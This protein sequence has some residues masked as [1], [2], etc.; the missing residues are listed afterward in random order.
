MERASGDT[1]RTKDSVEEMEGSEVPN[2]ITDPNA[3][4]TKPGEGIDADDDWPHE[5]REEGPPTSQ[6]PR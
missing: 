1:E 4:L 2:P 3:R 5:K 6:M